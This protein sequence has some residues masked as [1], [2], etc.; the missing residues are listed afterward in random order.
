M[1]RPF[2]YPCKLPGL[3]KVAGD[4]CANALQY[5]DRSS[6][7][8][9]YHHNCISGFSKCLLEKIVKMRFKILMVNIFYFYSCVY[10]CGYVHTYKKI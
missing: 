5:W 1:K 6:S 3:C 10:I 7:I 9:I 8:F 2:P 4:L